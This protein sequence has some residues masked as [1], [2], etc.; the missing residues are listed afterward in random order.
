M[1]LHSEEK[2]HSSGLGSK[3]QEFKD[4][5]EYGNTGETASG[6]RYST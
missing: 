1:D 3:E 5:E 6:A 4:G 2:M